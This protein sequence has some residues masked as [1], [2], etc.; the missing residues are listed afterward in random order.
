PLTVE[1]FLQACNAACESALRRRRRTFV[2]C[3]SLSIPKHARI[4][5]RMLDPSTTAEFRKDL[6]PK[7]DRSPLSDALDR[8]IPRGP[9]RPYRNVLVTTKHRNATDAMAR[10][11]HAVDVRRALWNLQLNYGVRRRHLGGLPRPLN[12]IYWGP[13][14]T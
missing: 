4:Q 10:A 3:G 11:R 1:S 9:E 5:R 7:W 2:L 12:H 13:V 8:V 6:P 14:S